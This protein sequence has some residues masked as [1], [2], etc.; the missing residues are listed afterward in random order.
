MAA[1]K[2]AEKHQGIRGNC[3]RLRVRRTV[4]YLI[5]APT[6]CV[7]LA[8]PLRAPLLHSEPNIEGSW[9]NKL[10]PVS[11]S[12]ANIKLKKTKLR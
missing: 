10:V 9:T 4:S 3:I 2:P 8:K 11:F 7:N 5:S 6:G 12:I 1:G